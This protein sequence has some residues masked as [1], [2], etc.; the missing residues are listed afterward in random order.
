MQIAECY[1]I[2]TSFALKYARANH[3]VTE[4]LIQVVSNFCI[5]EVCHVY[6]QLIIW[7]NINFKINCTIY[8]PLTQSAREFLSPQFSVCET[9]N[10]HYYYIYEITVTEL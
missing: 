2:T 4:S 10:H 9:D 6:L 8:V 7:N 1:S 3:C 5:H